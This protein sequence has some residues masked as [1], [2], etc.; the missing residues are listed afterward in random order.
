MQG[1]CMTISSVN[2]DEAIK[3]STANQLI[4]NVNGSPNRAVF[5]ANG[6]WSVPEGVHQFIVYL[7]GGGGGGSGSAIVGGGEYT[8]YRKGS[9][10]GHGPLCSKIFSGYDI[11]TSFSITIGAGGSAGS[12]G[13]SGGNGSASSFGT[14]LSSNGGSGGAAVE[15]SHGTDGS[16][17]GT[18]SHTNQLW[19]QSARL[20]YGE[21][22]PAGSG[23]GAGGAG[24]NG[25]C[26]IVW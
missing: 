2:P 25:I 24:G 15:D 20:G 3:A 17:T 19:L 14:V 16:H 22:G 11:G 21:G 1:M 26:V 5:T 23:G 13:S 6:T 10:G 7:A 4:A 18:M 9:Q 12:P 8:E